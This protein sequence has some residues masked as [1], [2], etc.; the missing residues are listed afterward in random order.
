MIISVTVV[1]M[2]PTLDKW[3]PYPN[4]DSVE[5]DEGQSIEFACIYDASTNPNIT[6]ATWKFNKDTLQNK[7]NRYTMITEY[8][9][10]PVNT[11]HVSSR[12]ILSTVVPDNAGNYTCQCIYNR[13]I[14]YS[15]G[16]VRLRAETFH[17]KVKP[18]NNPG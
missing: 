9:T 4:D 14:I 15:E 16:E 5:V 8:G 2:L 7:S 6:M 10:D 11:N 17:L 12:L 13:D 3:L 18:R 1:N